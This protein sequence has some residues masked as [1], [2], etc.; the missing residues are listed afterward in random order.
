[1]VIYFSVYLLLILYNATCNVVVTNVKMLN[2]TKIKQLNLPRWKTI[3]NFLRSVARR[4]RREKF[5][6]IRKSV[7]ITKCATAW[8][9]LKAGGLS[10]PPRKKLRNKTRVR[11][12]FCSSWERN[13]F[14]ASIIH[15]TIPRT[16]EQKDYVS[17]GRS[18]NKESAKSPNNYIYIWKNLSKGRFQDNCFFVYTCLR[19]YYFVSR[20]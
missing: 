16:L 1:M 2:K 8:K 12:D 19:L 13:F 9:Q 5:D 7:F 18:I 14:A 6:R 11:R 4:E 10:R 17:T 15:E 20:K 3:I